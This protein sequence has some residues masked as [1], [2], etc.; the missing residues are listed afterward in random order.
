MNA[1]FLALTIFLLSL[2]EL[3]LSIIYENC[4]VDVPVGLGYITLHFD[5]L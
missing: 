2:L 1:K 4:I 3:F 5:Q